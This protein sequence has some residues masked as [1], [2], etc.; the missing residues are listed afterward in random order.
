MMPQQCIANY[1]NITSPGLISKKSGHFRF[2]FRVPSTCVKYFHLSTVRN[3]IT[4]MEV[5]DFMHYWKY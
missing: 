3:H 1:I 2:M 4:A 5:L